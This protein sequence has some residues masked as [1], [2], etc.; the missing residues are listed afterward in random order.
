MYPTKYPGIPKNRKILRKSRRKPNK[1]NMSKSVSVSA[2]KL[3]GVTVYPDRAEVSRELMLAEINIG[4][5]NE[6]NVEVN[7]LSSYAYEKSVRVKGVNGTKIVS[8]A[9]EDYIVAASASNNRNA[10]Y[11]VIY[12]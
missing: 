12:S 9:I 10:S 8:V 4:T 6:F 2:C 11:E 7:E 3:L 1:P 5:D